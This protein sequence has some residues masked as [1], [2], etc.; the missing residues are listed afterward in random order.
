MN[1]SFSKKWL[2]IVALTIPN[3]KHGYLDY[4]QSID[5]I[6]NVWKIIA[7]V[8]TI[9]Y[10]HKMQ[11]GISKITLFIIIM[12]CYLLADTYVQNANTYAC[13]STAFSV[14]CLSLVYEV[15]CG[16]GQLFIDAQLFCY[17]VLI[18][19]N[20]ISEIVYPHGMY[21]NIS[22]KNWF[23][24]YYNTHMMF[25]LPA[26]VF[27][28]LKKDKIR[29]FFLYVAVVISS[30]LVWAG[31]SIM[32]LFALTIIYFLSSN[33]YIFNYFTYWLIQPL[34]FILVVQLGMIERLKWIIGDLLGKWSSLQGRI[35]VWNTEL[36]R[37]NKYWLFGKGIEHSGTRIKSYYG[38]SWAVHAHNLVLEIL[39]V[40]GL[41]Y[42]IIFTVI[43]VATGIKLWP[44]RDSYE[45]RIISLGF[46]G[47]SIRS[48]VDP[49]LF[50]TWMVLFV[51]AF[52][53]EELRLENNSEE[54]KLQVLSDN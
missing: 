52:R 21:K 12:E 41:F 5:L 53:I 37:L 43:I 44:H 33:T 14:I 8:V 1:I 46:L 35:R 45:V 2:L 51:L 48:T 17:E 42:L 19:L 4:C 39:H 28:F 34:F 29:L 7:F 49:Y 40:G 15:F 30:V 22:Y 47:W 54:V 20:L 31:G 10:F 50:A 16:D 18:Y 32:T 24:G 6:L 9:Y 25:F 3:L 36:S 23:L 38:Y 27:A 26:L 13:A 11:S